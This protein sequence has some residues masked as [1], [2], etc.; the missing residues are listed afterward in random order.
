MRLIQLANNKA[1]KLKLVLFT[2]LV[3]FSFSLFTSFMRLS[4]QIDA[5]E[6]NATNE[7]VKTAD[8]LVPFINQAIAS[9]QISPI[10]QRIATQIAPESINF[11]ELTLKSKLVTEGQRRST[12][13]VE[14][15]REINDG[16]RL[17][18]QYFIADRTSQVWS[19]F[20]RLWLTQWLEAMF[21][22]ALVLCG[23][24]YLLGIDKLRSEQDKEYRAQLAF[25]ER[26]ARELAELS[27]GFINLSLDRIDENIEHTL[28]RVAD[29][30][31]ADASYLW[32]WNEQ[33]SSAEQ[34]FCWNKLDGD[35]EDDP[36]LD[37]NFDQLP[38]VFMRIQRGIAVQIVDV[39]SI[40]EDASA[41]RELFESLQLNAMVMLPV[42]FASNVYGCLGLVVKHER[43]HWLDQDVAL[44]RIAGDML[45]SALQYKEQYHRL[46]EA[47]AKLQVI[48]E[49]DELTGVANRIFFN[50]QLQRHCRIAARHV[51]LMTLILVSVDDYNAYLN[52]HGHEQA[53]EALR[54]IGQLTEKLFRRADEY[55][56]RFGGDEF[57]VICGVDNNP[58]MIFNQAR[59]LRQEVEDLDI[60]YDQSVDGCLTVSIGVA[61]MMIESPDQYKQII[62]LADQCLQQAKGRGKNCV[63]FK[64]INQAFQFEGDLPV[65]YERGDDYSVNS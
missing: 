18:L 20:P 52:D 9:R 39:E 63:V 22:C 47:T 34:V 48:S 8:Y 29:V 28:E 45:S 50:H 4:A 35:D 60:E 59:K 11:I 33:T 38:W 2:L 26:F 7:L 46:G 1:M 37:I 19:R 36:L 61:A 44:L 58:E 49:I 51:Q 6:A 25:F 57:A 32:L 5:V 55:V 21:V 3:V 16:Q 41:E 12:D 42:R 56:A 14:Y 23:I 24:Y 13:I 10:N 31:Q 64:D 27:T 17:Y 65:L 15:Q 53:D 54:T 43:D 62:E 40:S 30:C